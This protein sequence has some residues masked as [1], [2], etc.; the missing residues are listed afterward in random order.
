[1]KLRSGDGSWRIEVVCLEATGS[2]RPGERIRITRDGYY[3][4][5]VWSV[6]ELAAVVPLADLEEY[7]MTGPVM[8]E[9]LG[10]AVRWHHPCL[11]AALGA[12]ADH[13]M[14][15]TSTSYRRR[16]VTVHP[17]GGHQVRPPWV[18]PLACRRVLPPRRQRQRIP[19]QPIGDA[20]YL[21]QLPGGTAY[22]DGDLVFCDDLGQGYPPT[23][24]RRGSG[25]PW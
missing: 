14:P 24:Y 19:H 18:S 15:L 6:E 13:Q 9:E 11:G 5:E 21:E 17:L 20:Q 22:G 25:R 12:A 8:A 2:R 7:L 23:G 10:A 4:G 16:A 1:M 3:Y